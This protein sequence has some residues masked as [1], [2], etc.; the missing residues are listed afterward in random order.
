MFNEYLDF[1]VSK[2][3]SSQ[4]KSWPTAWRPVLQADGQEATAHLH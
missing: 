1:I 4:L 2:F 3:D